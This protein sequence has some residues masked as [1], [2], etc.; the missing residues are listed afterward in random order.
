MNV[1]M[2]NGIALTGGNRSA[3]IETCP[4]ATLFTNLK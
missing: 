2:N 3:R 4:S 1:K